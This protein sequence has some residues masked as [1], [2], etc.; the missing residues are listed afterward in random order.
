MSYKKFTFKVTLIGDGAVGK[1]S[2]ITAYIEKRFKFDY[3][4]TFGAN[5][6]KKDFAIPEK[7]AVA[8]I[9]FWDI[10]G[11]PSFK[12]LHKTFFGGSNGTFLVFDVTQPHTFESLAEWH[13]RFK[14]FGS[15]KAPGVVVAN[16]IDLKRKIKTDQAKA[17]A[18]KIG[19]YYIETSAL[20]NRNVTE[21]FQYLLDNLLPK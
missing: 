12:S 6:M 19:Y 15:K 18:D 4:P 14:K 21:A 16:K 1:T 3:L 11:Q 9:N 13:K 7:N 10:A 8:S 20:Q 17:F 2:L 5:I